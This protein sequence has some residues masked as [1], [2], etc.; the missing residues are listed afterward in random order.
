VILVQ[1]GA[2]IPE[3]R[4]VITFPS[5]RSLRSVILFATL[6]AQ[7]PVPAHAKLQSVTVDPYERP[8][9]VAIKRIELEYGVPIREAGLLDLLNALFGKTSQVY[10]GGSFLIVEGLFFIAMPFYLD[11][12]WSENQR[13]AIH[14]S[15]IWVPLVFLLAG[16]AIVCDEYGY[17]IP[18]IILTTAMIAVAVWVKTRTVRATGP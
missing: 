8:V 5:L 18:N 2:K 13:R 17:V 9:A 15:A 14:H 4:D 1:D 10:I 3:L 6:L 16:A 12:W 11:F 7:V